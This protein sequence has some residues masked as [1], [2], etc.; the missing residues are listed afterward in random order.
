MISIN[1]LAYTI[2]TL[3]WI[4]LAA[5]VVLRIPRCK[6]LKKSLQ[7]FIIIFLVLQILIVGHQLYDLLVKEN[8]IQITTKV[9]TSILSDNATLSS[10]SNLLVSSQWF[11]LLTL[12]MTIV[13]YYIIFKSIQKC[14]ERNL[15]KRLIWSFMIL[16]VV[17]YLYTSTLKSRTE[18]K[19]LIQA[20]AK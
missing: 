13:L 5:F 4:A 1:V 2:I 17:Q 19:L 16:T 7:I 14:G 9:K 20:M 10:L 3:L 11:N 18:N 6:T 12:V 8:I 15:D